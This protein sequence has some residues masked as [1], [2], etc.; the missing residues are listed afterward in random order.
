MAE[1]KVTESE[2]L[3]AIIKLYD[4]SIRHFKKNRV[5]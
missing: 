5:L 2:K 3:D 1:N 4:A